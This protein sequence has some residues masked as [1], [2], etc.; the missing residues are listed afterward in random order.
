MEGAEVAG[1]EGQNHVIEKTLSLI[2]Q[3]SS[4]EAVTAVPVTPT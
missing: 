3:R 2:L 4:L 1:G